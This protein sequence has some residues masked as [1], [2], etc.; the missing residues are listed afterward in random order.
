MNF[1]VFLSYSG[2]ARDMAEKALKICR[3]EIT[4][5]RWRKDFVLEVCLWDKA[6]RPVKLDAFIEPN[7]TI[8]ARNFSPSEADF[9]VVFL[10]NRIGQG[11]IAEIAARLKQ[12]SPDL[13]CQIQIYLN[14]QPPKKIQGA[15]QEM[16]SDY[17]EM[18]KWFKEPYI[19]DGA[20]RK[21]LVDQKV[22]FN[23]VS[24]EEDFLKAFRKELS[25]HLLT[26]YQKKQRDSPGAS[27]EPYPGLQ[28]LSEPHRDC[29][30]GREKEIGWFFEAYRKGK[31]FFMFY[32]A[33]GVGKS[34]LIRAG[35]LGRIDRELQGTFLKIILRP[36]D[37]PS[38][39]LS[40]ELAQHCRE[41]SGLA[42]RHNPEAALQGFEEAVSACH[43]LVLFIDQFERIYSASLEEVTRLTRI[44]LALRKIRNCTVVIAQ[45]ADRMVEWS[46]HPD[47]SNPHVWEETLPV[48]HIRRGYLR[49]VIV[50]PAD[51]TKMQPPENAL[52]DR[53]IED[54][55]G[56]TQHR[57]SP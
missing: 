7:D 10:T 5:G 22:T 18:V 50:G 25:E 49:D 2:S 32:G 46:S 19:M 37:T 23:P 29:I 28:P 8:F 34:S 43:G 56:Q 3:E 41:T 57:S 15:T 26:E 14:E 54:F 52:V 53:L 20:T 39:Q 16:N 40:D 35:I 21:R 31:R 33:S 44:L 17:E 4:H 51:K 45:R 36:R 48:D 12:K 9:F 11:T 42:I 30:F 24:S 13:P 38:I 47:L 27:I 1:K 55:E 6:E